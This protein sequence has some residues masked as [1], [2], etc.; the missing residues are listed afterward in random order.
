[1]SKIK[2]LSEYV[3]ELEAAQ[4]IRYAPQTLRRWRVHG[5]GPP[6]VKRGTG[7]Y[8]ISYS[9]LDLEKFNLQNARLQRSTAEGKK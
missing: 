1:M 2:D 5:K 6:Y 8:S 3:S 9:R 4:I 7:R